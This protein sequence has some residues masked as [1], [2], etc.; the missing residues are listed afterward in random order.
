MSWI[1]SN[2]IDEKL[3]LRLVLYWFFNNCSFRTS[4]VWAGEYNEKPSEIVLII[5]ACGKGML[6]FDDFNNKFHLIALIRK[7][8]KI[9]IGMSRVL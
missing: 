2:I 8:T 4:P 5:Y 1:F 7:K 6:I 9:R 3:I